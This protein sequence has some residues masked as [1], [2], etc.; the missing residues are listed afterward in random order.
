MVLSYARSAQLS[1]L[2][3]YVRYMMH[4]DSWLRHTHHA[5]GSPT[6]DRRPKVAPRYMVTA[7][8]GAK[9]VK[10]AL[11]RSTEEARRF[12]LEFIDQGYTVRV[13]R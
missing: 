6:P 8:R 13:E 11:V 10:H 1:R 4:K 9:V 7:Y 5:A 3:A 12:A 2:D